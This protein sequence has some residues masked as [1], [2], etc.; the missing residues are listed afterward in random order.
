MDRIPPTTTYSLT[1]MGYYKYIEKSI[2]FH[3]ANT[4]SRSKT[5][6]VALTPYYSV[7]PSSSQKASA[8][9]KSFH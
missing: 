7:T 9:M 8:L 6:T 4:S 5:L 2:S 1:Y 3:E